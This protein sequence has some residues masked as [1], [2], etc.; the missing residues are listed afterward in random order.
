MDNIE[1]KKRDFTNNGSFFDFSS[2][3]SDDNLGKDNMNILDKCL[4]RDFPCDMYKDFCQNSKMFFDG[5]EDID[6]NLDHIINN[7]E[8]DNCDNILYMNTIGDEMAQ[9]GK[10]SRKEQK[11][12][13][14]NLNERIQKIIKW[15]RKKIDFILGP[16]RE[17][18]VFADKKI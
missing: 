13:V 12:Y 7:N 6:L 10:K 1:S 14:Y 16:K 8:K 18:S 11:V 3:L 4:D 5:T 9:K 15:K 17:V 2:L